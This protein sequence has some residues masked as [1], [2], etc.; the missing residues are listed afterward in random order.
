MIELSQPLA[1]VVPREDTF[2]W[3]LRLEGTIHRHVKHRR[4]LEFTAG[5][6][7]YFIKIHRGCGWGEIFKDLF[8]GRLPIVSARPEWEA[9]EKLRQ[10]GVSTMTVAGKG[11]RGTLPSNL[12]S[13]VI[14]EALEGM[15]SLETLVKEW[16]G[17]KGLQRYRLKQALIQHMATIARIMHGTG[18]NHRDFYLCH[19]LVQD[20]DWRQWQ[21]QDRL[22]LFLIDLHRVQIRPRVPRRW[23]IKDLAG[24]LCSALDWG[25]TKRDALRFIGHYQG[26]PWR[27]STEAQRNFWRTVWR[28]GHALYRGFYRREPPRI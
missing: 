16:G 26:V 4:T 17:V 19:F 21:K 23:V 5:G 18:L 1:A 27:K 13:F 28:R 8:S 7:R 12:D 9:I 25:A 6:K 24:L 2:D 20:R 22:E 14:T 3:L 11:L 15:V 10:A